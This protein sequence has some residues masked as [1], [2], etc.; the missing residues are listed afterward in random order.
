MLGGRSRDDRRFIDHLR[1]GRRI[2]NYDD[3]TRGQLRSVGMVGVVQVAGV[4]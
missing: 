4:V 1:G 3:V 2:G